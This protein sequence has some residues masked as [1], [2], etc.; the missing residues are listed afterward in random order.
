M[1]LAIGALVLAG[2]LIAADRFLVTVHRTDER[3]R[4]GSAASGSESLARSKPRRV[5]LQQMLRG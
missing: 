1:S 2:Q 3:Q 5:W 4:L